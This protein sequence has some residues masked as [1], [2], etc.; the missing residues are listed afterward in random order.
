MVAVRG[1]DF[2]VRARMASGAGKL[3]TVAGLVSACSPALGIVIRDDVPDASY[4]A[5]AAQPQFSAAGRLIYNSGSGNFF[6]GSGT[7]IARNWALTAAHVAD[8]QAPASWRF[9]LGGPSMRVEVAEVFIHPGWALSGMDI[10]SGFDFALMR[11][12]TPITSVTPAAISRRLSPAP[13]TA[14]VHTGFGGTS[15]GATGFTSQTPNVKRA[16]TNELEATDFFTLFF[17]CC[18]F[19]NPATGDATGL[20]G[21]LAPGDSGGRSSAIS[22]ALGRSWARSLLH[23]GLEWRWHPRQLRRHHGL[24]PPRALCAMDRRDHPAPTSGSV[25]CIGLLLALRRRRA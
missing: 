15:T 17:H 25:T 20:E 24:Q 11:L 12:A 4:Q 6:A 19:D 16:S 3:L 1:L 23:H 22:A 9:D 10:T 2:R 8:N 14:I 7:L 18:D 13:G 21:Q 5:L